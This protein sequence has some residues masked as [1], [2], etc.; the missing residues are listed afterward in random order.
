HDG[1]R[2]TFPAGDT[3]S[4]ARDKLGELRNMDKGKFDWKAE[5]RK[6]EKAITLTE[7]ID[8]TYLS[9]MKGARSYRT[10]VIHCNTLKRLL[11]HLPLAEVTKSKLMEY[12]IRRKAEP[13][14][15][16]GRPVADSAV[17]GASVNREISTL[18]AALNLAVEDKLIPDAPR[19]RKRDREPESPREVKLI[20]EQYRRIL[21][22]A[23]HR[24]LQRVIVAANEA[25][26]DRSSI[27]K[28]TWDQVQD[29]L[30]VVNRSKTDR[31]H[32]VGISP[33]LAE[34]LDELKAEY[35]RTPNMAK[36]V[37]TKDA[38][39]IRD[40][41]LRHAFDRAMKRAGMEGFLLKDFRHVARTRW[42]LMGLPVEVCEIGLG[43]SLKGLAKVYNN[44]S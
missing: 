29:G 31:P 9:V 28:L 1:T 40:T 11:G 24:W 23:K 16:H 42:S 41:T 13:I 27:L 5:K 10:K 39:P 35:K 26:L 22:A 36:L 38:K 30:I 12:R 2:R 37:F 33:A 14:M 34:V 17:S 44:P 3:L 6:Q 4:D 21:S 32:K 25:A 20:H 15:R 7:Y 43:H 18:L 8:K 19:I